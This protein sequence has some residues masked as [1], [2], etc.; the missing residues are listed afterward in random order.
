MVKNKEITVVIPSFN[1]TENLSILIKRIYK[2]FPSVKIVIVDD[3][4]PGENKKLRGIVRDQKTIILI[5][6]SKKSGRGSAVLLGF[7][8]ALKDKDTKYMFEMDSD[9]AHNPI[10]MTRFLRKLGDDNFDVI[11]GSR[12]L[13]GGKVDMSKNRIILSIIIN[14]FL[15]ILLGVKISDYTGGFRLY[16]RDAVK[17]LTDSK[18]KSTGFITLSEIVYKLNRK[19]FKIGEVPITVRNRK[20]GKSSV[21]VR[22]YV[23]SLFFVLKMRFKSE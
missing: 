6:R 2:E 5:S 1:E 12:Y 15:K 3:S 19:G 4:S 11:I 16:N 9:L 17:F 20:H 21:D 8:E 10:E 14:K 23:K 7:R 18:L 22:E 13:S